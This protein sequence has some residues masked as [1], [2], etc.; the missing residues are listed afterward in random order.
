MER[1]SVINEKRK[2]EIVLLRGSGCAYKSAFFAIITWISAQTSLPT[3]R[4]IRVCSR[5]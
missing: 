4:L 2:R 5:K 1:Y 3:I